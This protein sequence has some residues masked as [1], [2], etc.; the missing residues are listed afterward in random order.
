MSTTAIAN[1]YIKQSQVPTPD[2][3]CEV[4][5]P[6]STENQQPQDQLEIVNNQSIGS[7][8]YAAVPREQPMTMVISP[9]SYSEGFLSSLYHPNEQGNN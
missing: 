1:Q 5:F 2:R 8:E 7:D 3:E 4:E 9:T 6:L